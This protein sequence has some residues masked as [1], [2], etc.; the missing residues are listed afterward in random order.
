[1]KNET[2]QVKQLNSRNKK[3]LKKGAGCNGRKQ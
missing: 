3:L 1:M 2:Q